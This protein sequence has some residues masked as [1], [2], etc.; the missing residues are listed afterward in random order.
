MLVYLTHQHFNCFAATS[1]K[2]IRTYLPYIIPTG[3]LE[4][5]LDH[6]I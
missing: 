5:G 4:R 6:L 2:L 1:N 3:T